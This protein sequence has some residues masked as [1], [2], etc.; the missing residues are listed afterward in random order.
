MTWGFDSL[1]SGG[2]AKFNGR[3]F[4]FQKEVVAMIEDLLFH[5][6][7]FAT[8]AS[9]ILDAWKEFNSNRR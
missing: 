7:A 3:R 9:F 5:L 2:S 8:I 6:A 1:E 4:D